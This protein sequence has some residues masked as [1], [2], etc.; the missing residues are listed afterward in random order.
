MWSNFHTHSHYCDGKGALEDYLQEAVKSDV[1]T[2]GFSSH[3]PVPFPCKW[4]INQEALPQYL[5]EIESLKPV[6]PDLQIYKGLEIDFIPGVIAPEDFDSVLDYTIGSIHIVDQ[7]EGI[8]WEIDN[9]LEVFHHGLSK[10]FQGD[11]RK[12]ITRYYELT[13]AMIESGPPDIV[14]HLDKIKVNAQHCSFDESERWYHD[15]IDKTLKIIAATDAIVEVNTRGLY[16]RKSTTPYPSPWI[17]ERL[18]GSNIPIMLN[19][20]AHHPEDLTREF[21]PA[22]SLLKDIGFKHF[23]VLDSGKWKRMPLSEYGI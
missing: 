17:L 23:S 9:T 16:K 12:A 8:H 21:E 3:A 5:E 15:E 2:V 18:R 6:F 13:R 1:R 19:S 11:L 20:D 22:L 14:G 4:C 10:I 7:F